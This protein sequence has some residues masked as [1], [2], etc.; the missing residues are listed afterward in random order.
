M[1]SDTLTDVSSGLKLPGVRPSADACS[2][3]IS[4]TWP[5]VGLV[6]HAGPRRSM[7]LIVPL[8][9]AGQGTMSLGMTRNS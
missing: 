2:G 6:H 7:W 9:A 3:L 1:A 5:I 4:S 8:S